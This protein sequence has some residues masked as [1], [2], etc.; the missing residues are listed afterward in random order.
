MC[1][2]FA[3]LLEYS[4]QRDAYKANANMANRAKMDE[5][6]MINLRESQEQE[7]AAQQQI[8]QDLE[9]R[10]IASRAQVA[11]GQTGGFLN[12]NVVMQ[13]IVRQGLEA[14]TMTSQN[15][16]RTTAQLGE[17]RRGA[18]TRA[19]SRINSVARPSRTATV[20]KIGQGAAEDYQTA[21]TFG[22]T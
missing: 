18:A 5:D 21:Q 4:A 16:E 6:R 19:Q 22:I 7:K 20:L 15:L 14:N 12:N 1:Q 13:D 10:Q 3:P 11:A 17:E 9:T 2:V 8:A